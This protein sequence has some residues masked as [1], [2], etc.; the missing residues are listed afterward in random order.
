[1][2]AEIVTENGCKWIRVDHANYP[3]VA[4]MTYRPDAE[5]F[6]AFWEIG[7][8]FACVGVYATDKGIND[9]S[10]MRPY[11]PGFWTGEDEYDFTEVD[12]VLNLIAPGGEGAFIIP[13][14][15]LDCPAWWEDRY[16]GELCRDER[17]CPQRQSFASERWRADARKALC[18]LMDH[19]GE[20]PW[21]E[22]VAG[23][24]IACGSTEE[25]TYHHYSDQQFRLDFSE[26]NRQ[27]FIRWLK[28]R[29]LS[30]EALNRAWKTQYADFDGVS[31]PSLLQRLY[32]QNGLYRDAQAEARVIDFWQYTSWLFADTIEYLCEAVKRHSD[33]DLLT[34]AFYGYIT[35]LSKSEKGH[36]ATRKLLRSP[37]IDFFASTTFAAPAASV[38]LHGKIYFQEGDVRTCL[39]R[40][41]RETLAH[42]DPC[43]GYFDKPAWAPRKSMAASLSALKVT[44]A[45]TI[46]AN[47]GVW[48]FDMFG[49]WFHAPEMTRLLERFNGWMRARAGDGY[50]SEIAVVIDETG[51]SYLPRNDSPAALTVTAQREAFLRLGASSDVYEAGD[52]AEERF[53]FD[54]YRLY[55]LLN[56]I[57]PDEPVQKAVREKLCARGNTVLW[58]YLSDPAET[59]FETRYDRFG[60]KR[61]GVYN[62]QCFP[63]EKVGGPSF[64]NHSLE[65]AYTLACFEGSA[66]PCVLARAYEDHTRILSLLPCL[67]AALLR[68]IMLLSGVHS[69]CPTEDEVFAGGNVVAIRALTAGHKRIVLPE[70]VKSLTDCET[71]AEMPLYEHIYADFDME[72]DE[73]RVFRAQI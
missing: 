71:G 27:R 19:I 28:T 14:V 57:R 45:R 26:P 7:T 3:P 2:R 5:E 41:L 66:E 12:R 9:F 69:Y 48:W 59:G 23:Y 18:A 64:A 21:R 61:R 51:L 30:V 36:F 25:W 63:E 50:H 52:L 38:D 46:A 34:G 37:Y 60:E 22:R 17:G 4:Y 8:P 40:P 65:G 42:M 49:G 58:G 62:G 67:P 32:S 54:R 29:Y 53:P 72:Q 56:F 33:G 20:G 6:R 70:R 13:R 47:G 15:Y 43:N 73:T 10:G 35:L 44:A 11:G 68:E 31:F 39:T 55:I 1:M 16:P 24:H